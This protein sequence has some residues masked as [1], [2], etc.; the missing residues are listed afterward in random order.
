MESL[1]IFLFGAWAA[2]LLI[3][4]Q[5]V[6][7]KKLATQERNAAINQIQNLT[8][9]QAQSS[10]QVAHLAGQLQ[11]SEGYRNNLTVQLAQYKAIE[12]E[13]ALAL[14]EVEKQRRALVEESSSATQQRQEM[15]NRLK[16]INEAIRERTQILSDLETAIDLHHFGYYEPHFDFATSSAYYAR[17]EQNRSQQKA[18]ITDKRAVIILGELEINGSR[19]DGLKQAQQIV[20]LVL[21]AF[22]GECDGA[23]SRVRYNTIVAMEKR[24]QKAY[25]A[26][27]SYTKSQKVHISPLFLDLKVEELRIAHEYQEKLQVERE[28]QRRIKEEMREEAIAQR[29]YEKAQQEAERE[30]LRAIQALER[31]RRELSQA[32]GA[33]ATNAVPNCGTRAPSRRGA[34]RQSAC[35]CSGPTHQNGSRLCHIQYWLVRRWCL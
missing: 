8:S 6:L 4:N 35:H 32:M 29:E 10:A 5:V 14:I 23:I 31:A 25:E 17:L 21:R 27:N 20:R 13:K 3:L 2:T 33:S 24:I 26:I 1:C 7:A 18:M 30:E 12:K 11:T 16:A 9:E 19:P 28:E 22:N 15:A 34:Y